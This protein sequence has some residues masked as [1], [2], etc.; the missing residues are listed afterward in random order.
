MKIIDVYKQAQELFHR[1]KLK[2]KLDV[3]MATKDI[4]VS[5]V[6][7]F[8]G[9]KIPDDNEPL[10]IQY[11]LP[12]IIVESTSLQTIQEIEKFATADL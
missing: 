7:S 2:T 6:R 8:T 11:L 5:R 12:K 9:E 4:F 3:K 1:F 10:I